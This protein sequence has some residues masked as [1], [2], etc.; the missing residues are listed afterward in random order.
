MLKPTGK[1][2]T[3]TVKEDDLE[4]TLNTSC[5][6]SMWDRDRGVLWRVISITKRDTS[7]YDSDDMLVVFEQFKEPDNERDSLD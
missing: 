3:L 1:Y 5:D 4:D 6:R 2:K 7:K